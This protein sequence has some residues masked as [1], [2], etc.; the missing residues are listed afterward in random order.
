[1]AIRG[2]VDENAR[3]ERQ[4]KLRDVMGGHEFE[5][6]VECEGEEVTG[7]CPNDECLYQLGSCFE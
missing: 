5:V 4:S 6:E 3:Q 2:A 1:V 7:S